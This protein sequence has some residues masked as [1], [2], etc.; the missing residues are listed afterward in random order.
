M[1]EKA[2]IADVARYA[3]VSRQTVSNVLNSPGW[4]RRRPGSACSPPWRRSATG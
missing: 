3:N 2:T 1:A 4:S